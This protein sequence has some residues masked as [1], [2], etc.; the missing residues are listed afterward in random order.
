MTGCDRYPVTQHAVVR[1]LQRVEKVRLK[2][3]IKAAGTH[4]PTAIL[5]EFA[6]K[7]GVD[8]EWLRRQILPPELLPALRRGAA[9]IRCEKHD[10]IIANEQVVTVWRRTAP[11]AR[12][13]SRAEMRRKRGRCERRAR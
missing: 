9:R 10:C 4:D 5:A 3:Y 11:A 12:I 1:Y 2:R 8:I 13:Q 6:R 7:T